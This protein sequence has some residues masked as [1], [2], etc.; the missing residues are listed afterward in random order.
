MDST[1]RIRRRSGTEAPMTRATR[2]PS[3]ERTALAHL[4]AQ[5]GKC[6]SNLNQIARGLNSGGDVPSDIPAA[7]ADFRAACAAIMR[8]LGRVPSSAVPMVVT[9]SASEAERGAA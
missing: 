3:I 9:D 4:L 5:L 1:P 2:R 7:L 6:G 8:T